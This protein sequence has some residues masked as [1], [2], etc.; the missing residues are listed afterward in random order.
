MSDIHGDFETFD[1]ALHFVKNSDARVLTINGDL[2]GSV[3]ENEEKKSFINTSQTL[4]N[5]L[6]QIHKLT[7]GQIGTVHN[8]ANFLL[9]GNVKVPDELKKYSEDYL[10][11]EKVAKEKMSEQYKGFRQRL[12]EL[13]QKVILIPGN[14]DGINLDDYLASENI[15]NKYYGE[16][17]G[18][19]FIGYGG[20]REY[21]IELP[22]DI[23]TTFDEDEAYS[24]LSKY[25]DAE[26]VLT[27]TV[28][29]GFEDEKKYKGE[30][31]LLAYLYRFE[32]SLILTG[33]IHVPFIVKEKKS[34]TFVAN[35]GN[36]GR[37]NNQSFGTFLEIDID[38][39]LFVKPKTM[40]K[41][42]GDSIKSSGL[43]DKV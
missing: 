5:Q 37:Y 11:F 1:K 18:I 12:D 39:N 16:V 42:E 40:Y 22:P 2:A 43:E 17:D 24:H 7:N 4:I 33:H 31:N 28:P 9:S 38:G 3:F 41:I 14:W 34:G 36:L 8:A 6:P 15:H 30:Y 26:I 25:G 20:A 10:K 13:K 35:P 27:Y 29:R 21:P 19:K 32:P 23:I